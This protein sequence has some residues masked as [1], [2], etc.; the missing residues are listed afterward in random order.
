MSSAMAWLFGLLPNKQGTNTS[1]RT[2]HGATFLAQLDVNN[3]GTAPMPESMPAPRRQRNIF[4]HASF[5]LAKLLQLA[6]KLRN[7]PCACDSSQAPMF[8]A[9]SWAIFLKFDDGVE[10]VFRSPRTECVE[11]SKAGACHILAS[12]AA[13][14]KYVRQRT[15]IP[16][17]E[18][19]HYCA[20]Y[21]NDIEIPYILM[22]KAAGK[23]LSTYGWQMP[24]HGRRK[25]GSPTDPERALTQ[26]ERDK[27]MR[28]LGRY[29]CQLFQ[30]RFPTIGSLSERGGEGYSIE[31]CLSPGHVLQGREDLQDIP[32]GPFCLE[33]DYYSSLVSALLLHVEL[34]PMEHRILLAPAPVPQEYPKFA[35]FY[36]AQMLWNDYAAVGNKPESSNNRLAY[37][38]AGW[39]IRDHIVPR[40]SLPQGSQRSG[41]PLCHHDLSTQNIFVDDDFN[42]TCV[43]DWAFSSTVPPA[44]LLSTPGLPHP[45][46]LVTDP[47]LVHAFQ[48]GF[49]D[50]SVKLGAV[51]PEPKHWKTGG[52]LSQFMLLVRLDA[53][54]DYHH[55]EALH[56]LALGCSASEH[57]SLRAKLVGVSTN[58]EL[59]ALA[60]ALKADDEPESEVKRHETQY[61]NSVGEERFALA[62]K[63]T[64][65]SQY[66]PFFIADR[67]LWTKVIDSCAVDTTRVST[68]RDLERHMSTFRS[69]ISNFL[70]M[71]FLVGE[72][73]VAQPNNIPDNAWLLN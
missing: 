17:P 35:E 71:D 43:I 56:Q 3:M 39:Y 32:R 29:A 6:T 47:A 36:I 22:S 72:G 21:R 41:F 44:Q 61:F 46:D 10:W 18:V 7:Q 49:E 1:E 63:I 48:S 45:R 16:V 30:F 5:N 73:P 12:E 9:F 68:P 50:E 33:R 51:S 64:Q 24:C 55:L 38:L 20:T 57:D 67:R 62:Q 65:L 27:I 53:L 69:H 19:F 25:V 11:I 4:Y 15:S 23:P 28:Q 42:I 2:D 14:L 37:S 26:S 60:E 54:Q 59:L 40:L 31:E 70:N 8:G 58:P 66:D 34:L 52:M 13:T